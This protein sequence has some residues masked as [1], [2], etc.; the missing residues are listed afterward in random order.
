MHPSA[1]QKIGANVSR[2]KEPS[3]QPLHHHLASRPNT[4]QVSM[5]CPKTTLCQRRTSKCS[6]LAAFL[7]TVLFCTKE[8]L[9]QKCTTLHGYE[10]MERL[11][12]L[13][14][15]PTPAAISII[16]TSLGTGLPKR[17]RQNCTDSG[18]RKDA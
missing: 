16:E 13:P 6:L 8:K 2:L 11:K 14:F 17:T 9:A 7:T 5:Q 4:P 18:L 3:S 1:W 12:C 10:R 15:P